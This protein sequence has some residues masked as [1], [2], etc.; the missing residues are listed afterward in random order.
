MPPYHQRKTDQIIDDEAA[1]EAVI[2]RGQHM[3]LAM[4]RDGEP[5]LSTVNYGYDPD[6]RRFYFHCA[7]KGKKADFLRAN[8]TVWGQILEDRGYLPGR[9]LHNYVTVQFRG[10]AT[11]EEDAAGKRDALHRM[12]DQLEPDPE[13]LKKRFVTD[14]SVR[15]VAVVRVDVE[16]FSAKRGKKT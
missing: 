7:L 6:Q 14:K 4:A 12:I 15:G 10:Q 13:P 1:I 2:E 11:F 9:C 16:M 8:G 5:Y 3:T